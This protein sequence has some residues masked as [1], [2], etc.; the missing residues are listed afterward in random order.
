MEQIKLAWKTL[1][2]DEIIKIR[3]EKCFKKVK[4]RDDYCFNKCP[5]L[6]VCEEVEHE[7]Q[8]QQVPRTGLSD[9]S[10]QTD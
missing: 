1:V 10:V 4:T 7:K 2:S 9:S 3:V 8:R 6:K 5:N